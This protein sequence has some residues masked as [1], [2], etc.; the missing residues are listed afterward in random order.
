MTTRQAILKTACHYLVQFEC[1]DC[2]SVVKRKNVLEPPV[3]SVGDECWNGVDYTA[4][5]LAMGDEATVKRA[6]K[7]FLKSI[8]PSSDEE[9]QPPKKKRH[10]GKEKKAG[11]KAGQ[12]KKGKLGQKKGA[13]DFVLDLG[14]PTKQSNI[15]QSDGRLHLPS[16]PPIQPDGRQLLP[17]PPPL[18]RKPDQPEAQLQSDDQLLLPMPLPPREP[19]SQ[20]HLSPPPCRHSFELATS[21]SSSDDDMSDV[22][23]G[24]T[25]PRKVRIVHT[26]CMYGHFCLSIILLCICMYK[27]TLKY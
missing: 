13:A 27:C 25:S 5:L 2:L 8:E 26:F 1:D 11:G 3:P 17:I 12:K 15:H 4:K 6:E 16:L 19:Q 21:S 18:Q 20:L 9:N 24:N 14:S 10:M 7:D 23:I 22:R